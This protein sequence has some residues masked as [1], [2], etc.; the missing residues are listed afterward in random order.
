MKATVL[1]A[2]KRWLAEYA[3]DVNSTGGHEHAENI[4]RS[5]GKMNTAPEPYSGGERR[6]I[7]SRGAGWAQRLAHGFVRLG[8]TANTI[9]MAGMGAGI[10]AGA[11][12]AATG[13]WPDQA[14]FGWILGAAL[15]QVRLLAN[16]LDG[17][18]A[19]ETKTAS[20]VGELY[21]EVPDRV[22][23]AGVMIGL[24][25]AA[26]GEVVL[27]YGAAGLAIMVAYVR[28]MGKVAGAHQE[29]CGPLAKPQRMF[30]ITMAALYSGLAPRSWPGQPSSPDGHG[31]A[32][33]LLVFLIVGC[34]LTIVRRL[35]RISRALRGAW[36]P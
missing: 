33:G 14:R 25:Y 34:S 1:P 36:K 23:D 6:P 28:A 15:I 13:F 12:L 2:S 29:F 11:A 26:G 22:S 9:S 31:I 7:T 3:P 32:F 35:W 16:M 5:H 30:F 4:N 27:G 10:L 17:M 20:P 19:L 24:G 18:V 8:V 21:N